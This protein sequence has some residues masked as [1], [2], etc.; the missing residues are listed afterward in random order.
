MCWKAKTFLCQQRSIYSRLWSFHM[1]VRAGPIN[2][3][4]C[5]RIDAFKL[6]CWRRLRVPWTARRNQPWIFIGRTNAEAE[7]PILWLPDMKSWLVGKDPD[8]GKDWWQEEKRAAEDKMAGRHHW[9]NGH[10]L[11]QTPGDDEGQGGLA[12]C[13][14]WDCKELHPNWQLNN[15]VVNSSDNAM[16]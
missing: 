2:K 15:N 11:G 14:S 10:E 6:W 13:S 9:F 16:H 1:V 3:A 4:E 12:Y 8:A 7:A 5:L